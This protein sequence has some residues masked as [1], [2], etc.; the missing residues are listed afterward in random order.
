MFGPSSFA[1][2][3]RACVRCE[4]EFGYDKSGSPVTDNI[5]SC[6]RSDEKYLCGDGPGKKVKKLEDIYSY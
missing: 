4:H 1:K 5:L 2:T 3:Q 6:V